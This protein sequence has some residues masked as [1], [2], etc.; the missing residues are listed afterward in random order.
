MVKVSRKVG[1]IFLLPIAGAECMYSELIL[2][3]KLC[4]EELRRF[5]SLSNFV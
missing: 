3:S 1:D 5:P 2:F 4:F